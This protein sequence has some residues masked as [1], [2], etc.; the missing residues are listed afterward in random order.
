MSRLPR[1][2]MK[3]SFFHVI[4]QGIDKKFIFEKPEDIKY[5]IKIMYKIKEEH[6]INI[7]AYCIMNNHTHMLI[8]TQ[9][10]EQLSKYMQR[11]NTNME[12]IIIRNIIELAMFLEI[13]IKQKEYIVKNIYITV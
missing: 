10:I 6:N 7:I 5:Y 8:E 13:D 12:N 4:T 11:I 1:K 3:T 2:C 9:L